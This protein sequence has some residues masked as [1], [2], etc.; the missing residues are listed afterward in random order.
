[1]GM[2][3]SLSTENAGQQPV[4]AAVFKGN[5]KFSYS[6]EDKR[7]VLGRQVPLHTKDEDLR[8]FWMVAEARGLDPFCDYVFGEYEEEG[9]SIFKV[10]PTLAGYRFKAEET[11]K[12]GGTTTPEFCGEDGQWTEVWLRPE[13]PAACRVGVWKEGFK[14]AQYHVVLMKDYERLMESNAYWKVSPENSIAARAET[15]ALKRAFPSLGGGVTVEERFDPMLLKKVE[16]QL[17]RAPEGIAIKG[18]ESLEEKEPPKAP[19]KLQARKDSP[20]HR[21]AINGFDGLAFDVEIPYEKK[22]LKGSTFGTITSAQ[23]FALA[24][25]YGAGN[26]QVKWKVAL[27]AVLSELERAGAVLRRTPFVLPEAMKIAGK[28]IVLPL[29]TLRG[30]RLG[31]IE[32]VD[33]ALAEK[34]GS[35]SLGRL[36]LGG[37]EKFLGEYRGHKEESE[38][39]G[40]GRMVQGLMA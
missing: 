36:P 20:D 6:E 14:Q 26:D 16:E 38:N 23:F 13:L 5:A 12:Y 40:K 18:S 9:A 24:R 30:L 31:R 11:G 15:G 1:M 8:Y 28:E 17:G 7:L 29:D 32:G 34:L 22:E 33:K 37:S 35:E 27:R 19:G 10:H 4:P 21:D 39:A 25:K 3:N 2:E